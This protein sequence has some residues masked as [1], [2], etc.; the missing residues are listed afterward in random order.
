MQ[1]FSQGRSP[2]S[3]PQNAFPIGLKPRQVNIWLKGQYAKAGIRY[4]R[5][6]GDREAAVKAAEADL[7]ELLHMFRYFALNYMDFH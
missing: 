7:L 6:G 1:Y 2:E 4:Q 3:F 5:E